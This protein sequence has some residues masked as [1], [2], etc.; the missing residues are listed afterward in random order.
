MRKDLNKL[1]CERERQGSGRRF[2]YSRRD[3]RF[4]DKLLQD[5]FGSDEEEFTGVGALPREGMR[6][7]Y[8]GGDKSFSENLNPL[9]GFIRKS[10]GKPWTKV[11]SEICEVFD[12]R[13]VINQHILVHLFQY[14]EIND[15]RIGEDNKLYVFNP[16]NFHFRKEQG[17][18]PLAQSR[19][20]YYVDPRDGILKRNNDYR[21]YGQISRAQRDKHLAEKAS[22]ER[23]I[24][25]NLDLVKEDGIWYAVKYQDFK[26]ETKG[27]FV[28]PTSSFRTKPY[29]KTWIE[30]PLTLDVFKGYVREA[31][32]A[33]SKRQLSRRELKKYG[34]TND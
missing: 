23:H 5:I 17:F 28:L 13:S 30:Y 19:V 33:V 18:T 12:K 25:K 8:N 34:V 10:I 2:H 31:R 6:D 7:R 16:Y 1:L 14:V 15:M 26:G 4:D 11:Y 9:Y 22:K 29:W 24:H 32:V 20:E 3:K 21:T 27:E